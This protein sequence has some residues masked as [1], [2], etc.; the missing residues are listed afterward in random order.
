[1]SFIDHADVTRRFEKECG[2][3]LPTFPPA[4]LS[5]VKS[6][7]AIQ[8]RAFTWSTRFLV[9]FRVGTENPT[10][11]WIEIKGRKVYIR[12]F[13]LTSREGKYLGRFEFHTRHHQHQADRGGR[14][15]SK[16][17]G[18]KRVKASAEGKLI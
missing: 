1:M 15:S 11:F 6:K 18:E 3:H 4:Q 5:G 8:R 12:D 13:P 16:T 10:D 14:D 9:E 7:T 17:S 2:A